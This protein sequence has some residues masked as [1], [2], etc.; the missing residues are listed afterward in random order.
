MPGKGSRPTIRSPF[1]A[2]YAPP[3]TSA[4]TTP[5]HDALFDTSACL[6]CG[7]ALTG[8][9][10]AHCGQKKAARMGTRMVRKDAWE[11]FRWFEWSA[12]RNALR[13]LP[14]PGTMARAYVL[15][16]RKD[17]PHPLTLLFLSIGFLLILLGHTDYLRPQLP[18]EAAQRMVAL[19]TA[20]SKWSFSLGAV[21]AFASMWLVFR[22]RGYNLAE[23]L[24]LALYCQAV[25]I[26]LQ[27]VNQLPLVLAHSPELLKWHKQ[28]SPWY[29]TALQT[30]MFMLALRQFFLLDL[31]RDAG[32]LLLAGALFAGLKWQ[33]TQLYARGV[34]ELVLWQMGG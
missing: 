19:V 5:I 29:M 27:M 25:F 7:A 20:Y 10:C 11:R 24:A 26:A 16:Q 21:A 13:V 34:V 18:S 32:W 14:Q 3:V 22:R 8:P 28:W 15:G 33:A 23:L 30:L 17:H 4:P 12:I 2:R 1:A 31:R 6:N 9:F